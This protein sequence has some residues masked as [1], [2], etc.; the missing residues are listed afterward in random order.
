MPVVDQTQQ[1]YNLLSTSPI[2]F[3]IFIT[4][5][6]QIFEP[7]ENYHVQVVDVRMIKSEASSPPPRFSAS[8][9]PFSISRLLMST[10]PSSSSSPRPLDLTTTPTLF[11][12]PSQFH[13]LQLLQQAPKMPPTPL[14]LPISSLLRP[15]PVAIVRPQPTRPQPPPPYWHH[16]ALKLYNPPPSALTSTSPISPPGR[17][18]TCRFCAKTFPRS[19]NLTRHIRTHTG[20]A[21]SQVSNF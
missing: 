6:W 19:A 16:H 18:Y 7:N 2:S 15:N 14:L 8:P 1:E 20:I 5:G 4:F 10:P 13:M 3:F 9:P 21:K 12:L 11:P 17:R